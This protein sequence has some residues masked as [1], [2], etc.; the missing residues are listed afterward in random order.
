MPREPIERVLAEMQSR[1]DRLPPAYASRRVFLQTY[2]RTTAAVGAAI[3]QGVFEDPGWVEAWDVAFAELYLEALDADVAGR[4]GVPRPWRSAFAAPSTLP[5]LR[6]VLVGINAHVNYDLP[7]ALLAVISDADFGDPMVLRRR[8]RDHERIDGV[9]AQRVAAED[10]ELGPRTSRSLLDRALGPV[11]RWASRRFL[12]EARQKVWHNTMQLQRA[13]LAGQDAY[14]ARL[15]ELE[16]LSGDRVADLLAPGQV[17][18]RL[19]VSGFGVVLP[20]G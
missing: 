9:L 13:R 1:L 15:H 3:R 16:E 14:A 11:N 19:A 18:L 5:P 10:T 17:L 4:G 6:Q 12:R 2:R 7:Q 20:A 8:R